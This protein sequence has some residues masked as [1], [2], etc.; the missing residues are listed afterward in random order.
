MQAKLCNYSR[1]KRWQSAGVS[2]DDMK[3][4]IALTITMALT[5]QEDL[6]EYWS[7]DPVVQ[8]PFY[9]GI[10]SRLFHLSDNSNYIPRGQRGYDPLFKL[11]QV[12][13]NILAQFINVYYPGQHVCIDEGMVPFRGK[14]HMRVYVPD[15]PD[16]Y[17][18]KSYELCV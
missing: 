8:T 3:C 15:K 7:T 14:I 11:G 16:K 12:Y 17:G 9:L 13:K 4:F 5:V 6:G 1:L 10:M 2:A 18:L